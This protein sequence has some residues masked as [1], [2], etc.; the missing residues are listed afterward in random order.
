MY[1]VLMLPIIKGLYFLLL[2]L[3][4]EHYKIKCLFRYFRKYY[5]G[6]P[7][8]WC[9]YLCILFLFKNSYI[10]LFVYIFILV[11]SLIKIKYVINLKI[12][13]RMIRLILVC[14]S[15]CVI[16]FV[17]SFSKVTFLLVLYLLPIIILFGSLLLLPLEI[18]IKRYYKI[19]AIRK[20]KKINP[21]VVCITGSY[22]KT[23]I[24]KMLDFIY[25][26]KYFVY[27]TPKSYNTPMGIASSIINNMSMFSELFFCEAGATTKGDIKEIAKMVS[28]SVGVI[29]SIGYQHM[30]SFK[31]IDNVLKTKWELT[32]EIDK[33]GKLV[34]N[35]GNDFLNGLEYDGVKECIGVN[36]KYGKYYACNVVYDDLITEFDIYSYNKFV[37]HIKTKLLGD[38]NVD[39]IVMC[40]AVKKVLDDRF[41]I[42]DEEFKRKIASIDNIENRL[43]VRVD[44]N[45]FVKFRFLD[46]SFNS[47][48]LGFISAANVLK[49]L[50]GIKC[51]I[52]PGIVDS[53]KFNY[54]IATKIYSCLDGIDDVVLVDNKE[55]KGLKLLLNKRG[56]KYKVVSSYLEGVNYLKHKYLDFDGEFVNIL[57]ENDLPDSYLMR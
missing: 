39:N 10:D 13:K 37:I 50:S 21:F 53:G 35:Y 41:Y 14:V 4:Q 28:P 40:Y 55:L 19:K 45:S 9:S 47:N 46:D 16:P 56:T 8:I 24:K 43:S 32:S 23:S 20:L 17:V 5:L 31:T 38:H 3:Q 18:Y 33:D 52:T 6:L 36:K 44:E 30:N 29:T 48:A 15:I 27:S 49:R 12:T 22:G 25:K 1:L 26:D 2:M 42:S 57:V 11:F 54:L 7:F 51:I 34:L